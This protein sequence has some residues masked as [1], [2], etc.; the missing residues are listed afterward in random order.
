MGILWS[1]KRER[2]PCSA[3]NCDETLDRHA[4]RVK[5][6]PKTPKNGVISTTFMYPTANSYFLKVR[7]GL[8]SYFRK[9]R[10]KPAQGHCVRLYAGWNSYFSKVRYGLDPYFRKVRIKPARGNR[11]RLCAGWNT[12]TKP[13]KQYDA[14]THIYVPN[15]GANLFMSA[16]P[17]QYHLPIRIP[18][19]GGIRTF[20]KYECAYRT[21]RK[22]DAPP[23][24]LLESTTQYQ[25][26]TF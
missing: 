16:A 20:R 14:P 18:Q 17:K 2:V 9:V 4:S 11:V 13:K 19:W 5:I 8:N 23:T 1:Y 15:L 10:S 7:C 26:R 25:N 22:Y 12:P 21:L 24:V 3:E 6:W